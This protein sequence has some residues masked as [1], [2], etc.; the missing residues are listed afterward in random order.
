MTT[1]ATNTEKEETNI[2]KQTL[3]N[4]CNNN[5]LCTNI[6]KQY[7]CANI[8][9]N[10]KQHTIRFKQQGGILSINT[11]KRTC[12]IQTTLTNQ[13]ILTLFKLSRNTTDQQICQHIQT[14]IPINCTNEDEK[15][16]KTETLTG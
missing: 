12:Q 7:D 13:E 1:I 15:Q 6:T 9:I 4:E 8:Q 3:I 11:Q 10:N 5:Q 2:I 16:W 14:L